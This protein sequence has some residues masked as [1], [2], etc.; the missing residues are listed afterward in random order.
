MKNPN[1]LLAFVICFTSIS[2]VEFSYGQESPSYYLRNV[3]SANSPDV[4][5][6]DI[7]DL[8]DWSIR[9]RR[10]ALA[11]LGLICRIFSFCEEERFKRGKEIAETTGLEV[12][13]TRNLLLLH[14]HVLRLRQKIGRIEESL[15]SDRH[16]HLWMRQADEWLLDQSRNRLAL[17]EQ[18]LASSEVR[19]NGLF[20]EPI[21]D[22]ASFINKYRSDH[23]DSLLI[24]AFDQ[25][26]NRPSLKTKRPLRSSHNNPYLPSILSGEI[27][28]DPEMAQ[29][30]MDYIEAKEGVQEEVR[31]TLGVNITSLSDE[32]KEFL[33]SIIENF[34]RL[35]GDRETLEV[36][37]NEASLLED[38]LTAMYASD[39][40]SPYQFVRENTPHLA[41]LFEIQGS[42]SYL[43]DMQRLMESPEN[44]NLKQRLQALHVEFRKVASLIP[45]A[46]ET[47]SYS[48]SSCLD[49]SKWLDAN[50]QERNPEAVEFLR[51][52][53][54]SSIGQ[55]SSTNDLSFMFIRPTLQGSSL[56]CTAHAVASDMEFEI[57]KANQSQIDIDEEYAYLQ[58]QFRNTY[59]WD[60]PISA[61]AKDKLSQGHWS[62]HG[63]PDGS[64]Y[65]VPIR[66]MSSDGVFSGNSTR[67]SSRGKARSDRST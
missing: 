27:Q 24:Q 6:R 41:N 43:A 33:G 38:A 52:L 8:N 53:N 10:E 30:W 20:D 1:L 26:Q 55:T 28:S 29:R 65:G 7:E 51:T 4:L 56:S 39:A 19:A 16:P 18:I 37:E 22:L 25:N 9:H 3:S 66:D 47:T 61:E 54:I 57:N 58:L 23:S 11:N 15:R 48:M 59:N 34:Y 44:A 67:G 36:L 32:E 49:P 21:T 12:V 31:R 64:T 60:N 14:A 5:M 40:I 45:H 17:I 62:D 13:R 35:E 46:P 2:F 63:Y 50:M 42:Y